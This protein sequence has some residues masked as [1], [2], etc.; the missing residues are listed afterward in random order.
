MTDEVQKVEVDEMNRPTLPSHCRADRIVRAILLHI[1]DVTEYRQMIVTEIARTTIVVT[2]IAR[3]GPS[4][5]RHERP[6]R[7]QDPPSD[8]G[9]DDGDGGGEP[10]NDSASDE[11]E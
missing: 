3:R 11:N 1:A 6:I 9:P 2:E 7:R 4:D 5:N 10:S 8:D